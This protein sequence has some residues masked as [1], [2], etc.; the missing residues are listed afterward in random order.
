[1]AQPSGP[2]PENALLDQSALA[3][4]SQCRIAPSEKSSTPQRFEYHWKLD[5]GNPRDID[6]LR[7]TELDRLKQQT[8]DDTQLPIDTERGVVAAQ[9]ALAKQY[10]NGE[11]RN[12]DDKLASQWFRRAAEGGD[13]DAQVYYGQRL[14][15]GKGV[16]RD[17]EAGVTW[18]RK[19]AAQ[20][21][22]SAAYGLGLFARAGRGMPASDEAAFSWF[23][24]A[25]NAGTRAAIMEVAN[26]YSKGIGTPRDDA[27]VA[28]W[29]L[30]AAPY[31]M[32][33]V[34]QVGEPLFK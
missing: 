7:Q 34:W 3:A 21:S 18:L 1:M 19:A 4:L 23:L 17:D 16:T 10:A 20:G 25:A 9:L 31:D 22:G 5:D 8:A 24:Q 15:I 11:R 30:A 14:M 12:R 6:S 13:V 32:N 26:A 29:L 28:H 33:A 2:L 27:Q